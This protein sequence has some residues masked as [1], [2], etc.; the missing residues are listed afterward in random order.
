[1]SAGLFV[2]LKLRL[3]RN[4]LRGGGRRVVIFALGVLLGLWAAITGFL[5][6]SIPG[7]LG[8]PRS[9]EIL[10]PLAGSAITL[11]WLFLPLLVFGVDESL[12]PA[13]FALLPLSR[14]RLVGGLFAAALTG[15]P[16]LVTLLATLGMVH[17]A[18]L[19]GGLAAAGAE[20]L[21]VLLGLALC[22]T[23]SRA[24]TSAFA[25]A[26][27]GRRSRDIA[28]AALACLIALIGPLQL[29][30]ASMLGR[31]DL[32]GFG[33]AAD[34]LA[35]TPLGAAHSLG[36]DV[37]AGRAWAV[38]VKV[39]LVV[40]V[41]GLLLWWWSA[42]LERAMLGA[43]GGPGPS[44]ERES[45]RSPIAQLVPRLLPRSR[46]GALVGR[47]VRYWWRET[48]R[49]STLITFAVVGLFLPVLATTG[50]GDSV[51]GL[52]VV[53]AFVAALAAVSLANQF[54]FDGSALAADVAAG[55]PGRVELASRVTAFSLY[56]IPLLLAAS[57]LAGVLSHHP[58]AV[59]VLV[60]TAAAGYGIGLAVA[61]PLSVV[62]AYAL[63][64]TGNPFAMNSGGGA[65]KGL[66]SL[67]GMV[68]ATLATAPLHAGWLL[69][70]A[71]LWIGPLAGVAYGSVVYLL[72]LRLTAPLLDR[73]M[74]EVLASVS[75]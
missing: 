47:E 51:V 67:A 53:L 13:R 40:L 58:A 5:G 64:D 69:G 56:A 71:W 73:R 36:S 22:V 23:L 7:L 62:A 20:L 33:R 34:V 63:P 26:L 35:W 42:S 70:G 19:L 61:M 68:V 55:V 30:L 43:A 28:T 15:I 59:G 39:L 17:T 21:G 50:D 32:S 46:F 72:G 6:F 75:Q 3:I 38:P 52:G 45:R 66:V 65:Q 37:V 12:D 9:A 11:G 4:G 14:R 10:L 44:R 8:D 49:R 18:A 1:M 57:L 31:A 41:I 16:P 25:T 29:G 74:P 2:R 48:R 27:R 60:G 24:V 54:G